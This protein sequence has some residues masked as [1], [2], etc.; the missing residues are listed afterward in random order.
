MAFQQGQ[1]IVFS[2]ESVESRAILVASRE[3]DSRQLFSGI[4]LDEQLP[5][6]ENK[7]CLGRGVRVAKN[8]TDMAD[9][10]L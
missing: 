4:Q 6:P 3:I 8:V 10:S 2:K 7:Q 1:R 9:I 5:T